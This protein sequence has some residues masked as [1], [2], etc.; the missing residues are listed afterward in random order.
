[1]CVSSDFDSSIKNSAVWTAQFTYLYCSL[2]PAPVGDVLTGG[3]ILFIIRPGAMRK[4]QAVTGLRYP[5]YFFNTPYIRSTVPV[6]RIHSFQGT[7][8]KKLKLPHFFDRAL[9]NFCS[10]LFLFFGTYYTAVVWRS[11]PPRFFCFVLFFS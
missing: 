7:K 5:K 3:V 11:P 8:K 6:L 4:T 2:M 9:I 1:M 10:Y